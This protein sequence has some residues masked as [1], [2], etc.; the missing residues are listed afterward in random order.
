MKR[1]VYI[2][3]IITLFSSCSKDDPIIS[4][5]ESFIEGGTIK[6]LSLVKINNDNII[7]EQYSGKIGNIEILLYK[8]DDK[9]LTFSVPNAIEIGE[10]I[11]EIPNL[12][13]LK[14]KYEIIDITLQGTPEE[15]ISTYFSNVD[16]YLLTSNNPTDNVKNYFEKLNNYFKNAPEDEKILMAKFYKVNQQQF[17]AILN[18]DFL[19]KSTGKSSADGEDIK[20]LLKYVSAVLACGVSAA[21]VVG[22]PPNAF[23]TP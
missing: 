17:D 4:P 5:E 22:T 18:R 13:N 8:T 14:I 15:N 1:L 7:Q 3:A 21:I 10:N 6:K 9:E 12:N 19:N 11:L 20:I 16:N 23:T 2:L